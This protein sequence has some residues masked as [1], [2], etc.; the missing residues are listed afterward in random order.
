MSSSP[1]PAQAAPTDKAKLNRFELKCL[2]GEVVQGDRQDAPQLKECPRCNWEWF[3]LPN[4]VFPSPSQEK[5]KRKKQRARNQRRKEMFK[6][7]SGMPYRMLVYA[8]QTMRRAGWN[9]QLGATAAVIAVRNFFTPLRIIFTAILFI[10]G[11]TGYFGIQTMRYENA[12]KMLRDSVTQA[13]TALK[14]K[15][16]T[17]AAMEYQKADAAIA[18]LGTQEL[19]QLDVHY[20]AQETRA[21]TDLCQDS[22]KSLVTNAQDTSAKDSR[23]RWDSYFRVAHRGH[24]MILDLTI[25]AFETIPSVDSNLE[26][27][28]WIDQQV[29]LIVIPARLLKDSIST[30]KAQ[31]I[32]TAGRLDLMSKF[33]HPQL[34]DI[35]CWKLTFQQDSLFLWAHDSS[36]AFTGLTDGN[37]T[38]GD[39]I[40]EVLQRQRLING[41]DNQVAASNNAPDESTAMARGK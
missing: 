41:L 7:L 22:L 1:T 28:T 20:Y 35:N 31:R 34:P 9:I 5:A 39:K 30:G 12:R 38:P 13:E 14:K 27:V 19:Y 17:T 10:V 29:V 40:A 8:G 32:L 16:L 25:P 21:L 11:L 23:E 4:S 37:W 15:D 2:C 18:V 24:W 6:H 33:D 26:I 36:F 3:I